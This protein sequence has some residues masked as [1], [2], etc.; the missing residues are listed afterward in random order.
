[1]HMRPR[2]GLRD[3]A[4]T[5]KKVSTKNDPRTGE[6]SM[7][8]YLLLTLSASP[9]TCGARNSPWNISLSCSPDTF[10]ASVLRPGAD[11]LAAHLSIR[12]ARPA[13]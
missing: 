2:I 9:V 5:L 12:S 3:T 7:A 4:G 11:S 8:S 10:P 13:T 1:M 6:S